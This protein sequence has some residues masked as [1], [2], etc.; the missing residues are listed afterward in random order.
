MRLT[1]HFTVEEFA[2]KDGTCVPGLFMVNLQRLA[3]QLEVLRVYL[4]RPIVISSGY[5]TPTWNKGAAK[6]QHLTASAADFRVAGMTPLELHA[7]V[8]KLIARK[9]M[10]QGGVGLYVRPEGRGW[11]HYD[12]RGSRARW[13]G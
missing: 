7:A 6:S 8:L 10:M 3:D 4:D 9:R 12:I 2:C 5:R 13:T 1:P 11:L